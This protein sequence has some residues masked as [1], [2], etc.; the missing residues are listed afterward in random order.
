MALLVSLV[1]LEMVLA[2]CEKKT[3]DSHALKSGKV[4][5]PPIIPVS[6]PNKMPPKHAWYIKI[7]S[8]RNTSRAC[9]INRGRAR[10]CLTATASA[11]TRQL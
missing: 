7:Q 2:G 10:D 9:E 8:E 6:M 4:S 11:N 3:Q 5:T 1:V